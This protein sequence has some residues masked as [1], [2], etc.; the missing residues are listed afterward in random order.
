[1]H[2]DRIFTYEDFTITFK[3]N[4][5]EMMKHIDEYSFF[6]QGEKTYMK[7]IYMTFTE[8]KDLKNITTTIPDD[9]ACIKDSFINI[10]GKRRYLYYKNQNGESWISYEDFGYV[11]MDYDKNIINCYYIDNVD[12]VNILPFIM[13]FIHPMVRMIRKFN[14]IYLHAACL[15][16]NN[17]NI[18]I[19]GFSG[20][21]KSTST[22][23]LINKGY[24]A[25]TDETT[26]IK[27]NDN[28]FGAFTIMNYIKLSDYTCNYLLKGIEN[29]QLIYEDEYIIKLSQINNT[30]ITKVENIDHIF[31]LEKT[32]EINTIIEEVGPL[33]IIEVLLPN[34]ISFIDSEYTKKLFVIFMD[35]LDS[36]KCS[37]VLFGTDMEDFAEK[38]VDTV[39]QN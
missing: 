11:Y 33:D 30:V 10:N 5:V 25:L 2:L 39:A 35:L 12:L 4:S 17:K 15:S 36:I 28:G 31:I 18:L 7:N 22:Y 32:G 27:R 38:I 3:T 26:L 23:A 24:T 1:M 20:S 6:K 29:P 16:I 9:A 37:K 14:Y 19:T 34:A 8:N 13:L 21:G